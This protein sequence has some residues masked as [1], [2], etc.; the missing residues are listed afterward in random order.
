MTRG[1]RVIAFI[2]RFCRVPEGKLVGKPVILMDFQRKFITD[3]YDNPAGTSRAYLS[4][5]RKNGKSALIAGIV[6]AHLVGPEA[7]L[8]SQ[9]I[10]GARSRDQAAI[11]FAHAS[12]MCRL[13][14]ALGAL[15]Q[16]V[17]S[18]KK[19]VGAPMNVEFRAIAADAKTAHGLSPVLAVLDEVGQ[20]RGSKDDFVESIETA[21]GAHENPL[22]L[23]I[24]TQAATDADLFSLWL[25]DAEKSKDP[26]IVSHVYTAPADCLLDDRAAW[27]AANPAL[28][29]FREVADIEDY[30]AQ[31]MRLPEKETSFRWLYLNQRVE[32]KDPYVTA[33][34]WATCAGDVAEFGSAEVFGGLDLSASR[35]LTAWVRVAWVDGKVHVRPRFWLPEQGIA[36][37]SRSD[38]VPYDVWARQGLIELTPGA[39]IDY[40]FVAA[41][42]LADIQSGNVVKVGFDRWR[43]D[44]LKASFQR[45]G[46]DDSVMEIFKPFGQGTRDM[47]PALNLLDGH[48][49]NA[50]LCHGGHP[51][52]KMC[53]TNAAVQSDPS[54]NRKLVKL[55]DRRRI[56]GM[57]ALAMAV[58]MAGG[59]AE[60]AGQSFWEIA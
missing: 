2:E 45:L 38:H 51:V 19:L 56:D 25:D 21:Q 43:M 18:G 58:A 49:H 20:V 34:V 13:N 36:E 16:I 22:L 54:G 10:A 23:A 55:I 37:K 60:D 27:A 30:S 32:A 57:V 3:I 7:R 4:I 8:N 15:V 9:I 6:L 48:V 14:P 59:P 33:S 29:V 31:A 40:D 1:E 35:D 42:I 41:Q 12:K 26:R 28:G 39:T 50:R 47:G 11:I 17:P 53:A 24:S 44:Q 46:A 5:A 52:L